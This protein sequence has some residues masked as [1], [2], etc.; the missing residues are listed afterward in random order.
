[1]LDQYLPFATSRQAEYIQAVKKH[2][3]NRKAASALGV[4][5]ST[6][7]RSLDSLKK[8][9]A[10]RGFSP[11]HDMTKPVPEGFR[12]RGTSTLYDAEQKPVMQWVK[13]SA[14]MDRQAEIMKEAIQAMGESLPRLKPVNPPG[15]VEADLANLYILTDYHLGMKAWHEEAGEDWDIHIAEE[16]LYNWISTAVKMSP[17][18]HTGVFAQLGDFLHWDGLES[19][20][21]TSGHVLDA[22][23]RFQKV[24]RVAIRCMRRVIEELR[25]KHQHVIVLVADANHDPAGCVWLREWLSVLYEDEPRV[26]VDTSADTYYCVEWGQTSLFFHHGHKRKPSNIDDVFASKFR[27]VF[28]RTK[29]SYA[30]MGHLHHIESKETN[31]MLVEQHRTLAAKDAYAS[32]GGWMAGRDAKVITYHKEHGEVGRVTVTPE[33]A[34]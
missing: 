2:G 30:H 34:S 3:S 26:T 17:S 15:K 7:R 20:T 18:A 4:G 31:L 9:A 6:V 19:V 1:M 16:T 22:D 24:V 33:M 14:D 23:S 10:I 21:P 29:H 27:A 5:E 12:L 28:G 13:T 25:R 8:A 32:R 11:D